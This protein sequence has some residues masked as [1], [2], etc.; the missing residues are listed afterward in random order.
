MKNTSARAKDAPTH[1]NGAGSLA[2][3]GLDQRL[4]LKVL[5]SVS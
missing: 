3:D 5:T 4:L 1:K 2:G